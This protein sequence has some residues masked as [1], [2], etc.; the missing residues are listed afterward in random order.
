MT[1]DALS[2]AG[3]R[4]EVEAAAQGCRVQKITATGPLS[5]VL[6]VYNAAKRSRVQFLL[7]ADAQHARFHLLREKASQQPG[8][9][10]SFMLLLRKYV[11]YGIL[12][13]VE[14][15]PFE[16][17]IILNIEKKF[18][19]G[20]RP[21]FGAVGA[22]QRP[23]EADDPDDEGDED[24][25][26]EPGD[27]FELYQSKLVCEMMGRHSNIMLL[28]EDNVIIDAIKRVAPSKN[29]YRLILP[30][31]QY[32]VP[33]PQAKQAFHLE[34]P[35]SF[36]HLMSGMAEKLPENSLW[37]TLVSTFSGVSPQLGR[38]LAYRVAE[39]KGQPATELKLRDLQRWEILYSE[40]RR[41]LQPLN[42]NYRPGDAPII[43]TLVRDEEAEVVAFAPYP[44]YQ[45]RPKGL[46]PEE[47]ENISRAAEEFYGQ[48]ESIGGQSQRKA[49]IAEM[50]GGH[51]ERLRR[52]AAAMEGSLKKAE[53]ADDLKRKGEAIYAHIWEIEPG[54]TKLQADG[55]TVELDP[56]YTPS[57][58]AQHYFREYDKGRQALAGVP[59]LL[60]EARYELSYL[61]EMLTALD[62][63]ESFEEVAA[64][65]AELSENG[66]GSRA[67]DKEAVK[68]RTTRPKKRKMLQ[69]PAYTSPEGFAI[70]VGKS[71]LHNDYVTF[72]LGEKP[73]I[74]LHAR[75]MPGSHVI[76]KTGGR[77]V[78][79][80]TLEMAAGLAAYYSKGQTSTKV[81][82]IYALQKYVR[83]VKGPHPG[84]VT[85]S[86]ELGS[87]NVKP[88]ANGLRRTIVRSGSALQSKNRPNQV[89]QAKRN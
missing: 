35:A 58:N 63:A 7:S 4:Y 69:T 46:E 80:P 76:I 2:L 88:Q 86:Q 59:E 37:Q 22:G 56:D 70:Y 19:P 31:Q 50:I 28:S 26:A 21:Y 54:Q 77:D 44:L 78:P 60:E 89:N 16:R 27:D 65:R 48:T 51:H 79:P 81:E 57:E 73:D 29:R 10:G 6:E 38:E 53:S 9:P 61:D 40:M 47:V 34:S 32:V 14:Q 13:A 72:E 55:I 39:A 71:A 36:S 33:P 17:I 3:L 23:A 25:N 12:T 42:P 82:V 5:V 62:L 8:D 74:W 52:R 15:T 75:G 43:A 1:I 67:T 83:K 41:L 64:I 85:F 24:E 68:T 84:L 20:K 18:P 66:Y 87:L 45:F 30:H 11:R 49:Q